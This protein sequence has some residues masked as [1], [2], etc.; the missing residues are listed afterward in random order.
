MSEQEIPQPATEAEPP[1]SHVV[2]R[3]LQ[4]LMLT[5]LVDFVESNETHVLGIS[6]NVGGQVITG[7]LVGRAAW[8]KS[9]LELSEGNEGAQKLIG[10]LEEAWNANDPD[11]DDDVALNFLHVRN[12]QVVS[13][14]GLIGQGGHWRCKIGDVSGWCMGAMSQD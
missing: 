14:A 8:F 4:D 1:L 10:T 7:D 13:G 12:G 3:G 11:D 6:L 5:V 2:T 9:M